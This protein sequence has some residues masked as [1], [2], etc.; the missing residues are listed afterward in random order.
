MIARI[1]SGVTSNRLQDIP[2]DYNF[3]FMHC[4]DYIR[5]GIMCSADLAVEVHEPKD[6]DD[7]GPQDGGWS[8]HHGMLKTRFV[9]GVHADELAVCKDYSKVISYLEGK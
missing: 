7:F 9:C 4:V 8:G 2:E 6:S 3:H 5:Q 1:F